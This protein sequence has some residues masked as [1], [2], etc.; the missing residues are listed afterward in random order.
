MGGAPA[1][2]DRYVED[3]T[4]QATNQLPLREGLRL[5]M[6]PADGAAVNAQRLIFLNKIDIRNFTE[7]IFAEYLRK[8]SSLVANL[9][10]DDLHK[11]GNFKR[12]EFQYRLTNNGRRSC[13]KG[14]CLK[15]HSLSI[16][17]RSVFAR[18]CPV[19]PDPLHHPFI[20]AR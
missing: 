6:Q 13:A 7:P 20:P 14:M 3:S 12:P 19:P 10:G 9:P 4:A 11:T 1:Q 17:A 16:Q 8:I 2:I 18:P 15:I 5:K